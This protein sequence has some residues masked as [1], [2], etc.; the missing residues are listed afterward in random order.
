MKTRGEREGTRENKRRPELSSK[1]G[2]AWQDADETD[3]QGLGASWSKWRQT[4]GAG[5]SDP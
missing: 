2:S 1:R 3:A 5:G 4:R